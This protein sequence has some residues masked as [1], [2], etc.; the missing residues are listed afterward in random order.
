MLTENKFAKYLTYAIGEI[1]L[2]VIG[3]LIALQINNWNEEKIQKQELNDIL[4]SVANG[5]QSD[6]RE[7]NLLSTARA[8]IVA[9]VDSIQNYYVPTT[10]TSLTLVEA[11]YINF[12]SENIS[13][14]IQF[15]A[16]LSAFES[17]KNS[18]YFG[19]IQG[20]DLALLLSTYFINADKI[21]TKEIEHNQAHK[22]L[23]EDWHSKL[24]NKG[25]ELYLKPWLAEDFTLVAPQFLDVLRDDATLAIFE[26]ARYEAAF[27]K[28]YE[29]QILM[30]KK[31]VEMIHDSKTSFDQQTKLE[32]SSVLFSFGDADFVSI[33]TDG[34]APTAFKINYA[35][36]DVYSD[37]FSKQEDYL[38]IEYP[39][40]KYAWGS[41]YFLVDALYGR[42]NEMDF[43]PYSSV[44]LEMKGDVGGEVFDVTMKDVNDPPDGSESRV[45]IQLTDKW[46]VYEIETKQF[47]TADMN[48]I[49]VPLAFVFEGSE[50][51]K[52]KVR[53]IQFKKN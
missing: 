48:R 25:A 41:T 2:V 8:S 39:K 53:S 10:K 43:S 50:G 32:L 38:A 11:A 12:T 37:Y 28:P 27:L 4:Q 23:V 17:L 21:K 7:L 18:S 3:I 34:R 52:I 26:V 1:F 19:K 6:L 20:T 9:K 45:E 35:A 36:S 31:L 33:L 46:K 29:E 42:V 5:L 44:Y 51:K 13:N 49:M 15:N 40:N 14:T 24:K 30:G 16:N 47:V 22:K